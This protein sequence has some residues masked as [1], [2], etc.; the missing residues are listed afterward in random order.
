[1][2]Y[3]KDAVKGVSWIVVLRVFMRAV[4]FLKTIIL[5]RI[6]LPS[7]F[8]VYGIALIVLGFLEI[9]TETGVNVILV[10]E[11]ETDKYINSAWFVSIIRGII[12]ALVI[13]IAAPFIAIF[14]NSPESIT[15]LYTISIVPFI[16][17]FI[18]PSIV[19]FQKELNFNREF[20]FRSVVF[21]IDSF[22]SIIFTIIT[23]NPIGIIYGLILGAAAE[24]ILSYLII[25]PLPSF[26]INNEYIK[27]LF[28]RGK[29]ITVGGVFNYLFHNTDKL[30]VGKL[31]GTN[32]LG[33][34]QIA[35][36]F[37]ILP[38]TEIADVFSRVT[39]PVYVQIA[40][41]K[42]RLKKAF[43]KTLLV[44]II[45]T[46]P[47][48]LI[49]YF[50][51]FEI[52]NYLLGREWMAAATFLPILALF[53]IVRGISGSTSALFLAVKKQ[54]YVTTVTFVS[55]LGIAIPVIPLIMYYGMVG[56]ALSALIGSIM[57]LPVMV[58]YTW[59]VLR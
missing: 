23:N 34:Y 37:S 2:G 52:I 42:D 44:T 59:K 46:L 51:P 16:R 35:Y 5:A 56:A 45:L 33:I 3:T 21:A 30:M 8:G 12:I 24:A 58:Y 36:N 1:M 9:M 55:F 31:L 10:Q 7:Q 6:L 22:A 41:D 4:S 13:I 28:H 26:K 19:K 48:G 14:F 49:L 27:L 40:H 17:G 50:F 54:E 15:L 43:F 39:F 11:K 25:R 29:W 20:Y 57:A 18:N 32:Y 53:G 47:F 38:I